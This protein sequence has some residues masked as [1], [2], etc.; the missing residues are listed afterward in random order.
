MMVPLGKGRI[1]EEWVHVQMIYFNLCGGTLGTA[2][3]YWHIVPAP[4][5]RWWWLWRNW[6]NEDWQGKPKYS[7][8]TCP[9]ATL[10]TTNPTCLDPVLNP[11]HRGG[12]P[13]TNRLS[14]GAA[15]VHMMRTEILLLIINVLVSKSD[16]VIFVK[17]RL[18]LPVAVAQW[19]FFI[20]I[21]IWFV[22]LLALRPL[23]AYCASRGW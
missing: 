9:S 13:A 11:I 21:I 17:L 10:P 7:E 23:M 2:A 5:D 14:H 8:E 22:R 4:D 12:K 15:Y 3:T 19:S 16:D 18:L 1:S 6:W 20:I